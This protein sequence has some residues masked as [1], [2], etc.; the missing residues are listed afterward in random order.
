[1][2][3]KAFTVLSISLCLGGAFV[4]VL[5][6]HTPWFGINAGTSWTLVV[7]VSYGIV[8]MYGFLDKSEKWKTR[9]SSL[10][11]GSGI[12]TAAVLGVLLS[13]FLLQEVGL[14]LGWRPPDFDGPAVWVP[15]GA[16]IGFLVLGAV[17]VGLRVLVRKGSGKLTNA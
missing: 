16:W 6:E 9:L 10:A 2:N 1:M 3:L 11:L 12:V 15:V 17:G 5:L 8:L 4:S 7:L 14:Q 13:G